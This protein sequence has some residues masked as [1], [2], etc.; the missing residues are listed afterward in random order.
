M[1]DVTLSVSNGLRAL[2]IDAEQT[3]Q[4][5]TIKRDA[6][7]AGILAANDIAVQAVRYTLTDQGL[8]VQAQES[9]PNVIAP[10]PE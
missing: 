8:V 10:S 1:S 9:V 6:I 3:V 4:H 5:A 7:V 2:L